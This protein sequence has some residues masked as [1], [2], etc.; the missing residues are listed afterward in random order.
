M[1]HSNEE[2]LRDGLKAGV[3]LHKT[4]LNENEKKQKA[5]EL[6]DFIKY[7]SSEALLDASQSNLDTLLANYIVDIFELAECVNINLAGEVLSC[8][9]GRN[10]NNN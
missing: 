6:I 1:E 2:K 7:R 10:R 8:I 3:A 5:K 4:S 9:S